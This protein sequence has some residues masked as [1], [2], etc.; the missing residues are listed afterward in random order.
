MSSATSARSTCTFVTCV[1]RSNATPGT[2]S[3]STPP[4]VWGMFS[5]RD[6][7]SSVRERLFPKRKGQRPEKTKGGRR[8]LPSWLSFERLLL[9]RGAGFRRRISIQVWLTV[10]FLLVTV[11]AG[12]TAYSIVYPRLEGTLEQSAEASFRQ[13]GAK[14]EEDLQSNPR[15]T[16]Q[17]ITFYAINRGVRW[18]VV[19]EDDK[20]LRGDPS[21]YAA[22]V[23][24]AALANQSPETNLQPVESGDREGQTLAT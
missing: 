2:P 1:R 5:V 8:T 22:E 4:G 7:L 19:S 14:F 16:E 6:L 10:L 12:G 20:V 3:L 15:L 9:G 18:G 24:Q 17:Y 13:V 11:F 21:E 23:V